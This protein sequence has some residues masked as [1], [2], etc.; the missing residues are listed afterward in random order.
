MEKVR[1]EVRSAAFA[2]EQGAKD[3]N[4]QIESLKKDLRLA[5]VS[6]KATSQEFG[7]YKTKA[8]LALQVCAVRPRKLFQAPTLL[9]D[10]DQRENHH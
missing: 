3:K 7:D 5:E 8:A 1:E 6:L 9:C 4:T 2:H 10:T